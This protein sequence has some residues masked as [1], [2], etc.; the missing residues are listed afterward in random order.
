MLFVLNVING[1]I[2]AALAV[3][4]AAQVAFLRLDA[5]REGGVSDQKY[6]GSKRVNGDHFTDDA[7]RCNDCHTFFNAGGRAPVNEH[8]AGGRDGTVARDAGG[9]SVGGYTRLEGR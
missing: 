7:V 6:L 4:R 9:D 3:E 8:A 1:A 5:D 2:T